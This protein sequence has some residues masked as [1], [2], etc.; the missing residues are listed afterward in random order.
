MDYCPVSSVF[1]LHTQSS[2]HRL[3]IHNDPDQDKAL[4]CN[5]WMNQIVSPNI[6]TYIL[7]PLDHM[8]Q[9]TCIECDGIWAASE[10]RWHQDCIAVTTLYGIYFT[11]EKK[12]YTLSNIYIQKPK[13]YTDYLH[14]NI[15]FFFLKK[16]KFSKTVICEGRV[17]DKHWTQLYLLCAIYCYC[18]WC[19]S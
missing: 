4:P 3:W 7:P 6:E 14:Y 8:L 2:Q 10:I 13:K 5:E 1:P 12:K 17:N 19:I 9:K 15:F 16:K 11:Y 18:A